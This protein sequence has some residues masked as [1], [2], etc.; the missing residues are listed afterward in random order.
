MTKTLPTTVHLIASASARKTT[1]TGV[2]SGLM[3]L[4]GLATAPSPAVA[5]HHEESSAAVFKNLDVFNLEIAADPQISPDGKTVIY[6]RRS[7][8]IMTDTAR[9]N[10]WMVDIDGKNHR[11]LL[12]G[13]ASYASPRWSPTGDRIAYVSS[14]EG[15][16]PQLFVRWMDT[17]Q[18]ALITN[19][20]EAPGA[21][22]WSPDGAQIAFTMFVEKKA[23]PLATP[24]AQPKGATWAKPVTVIDQV[25][26]RSDGAGYARTG[27]THVFTAPADGG[28]PV[29][30]TE[31]DFNHGGGVSWAPD[32]K[33]ILL[34]ANRNEGWALEPSESE[35][36]EL[37]LA[38]RSLQKL[39]T[40]KGP[41]SQPRYSP[42]GKRIAYL[43]F[44]DELLGYHNTRLYVMNRD[45]SGGKALTANLDR[46]I[47]TFQWADNN[48]LVAQFDDSGRTFLARVPI[49]GEMTRLVRDVSGV[50]I[51][52]PYT[53]GGFSVNT[54]GDIAYSSGRADR[55]A[56]VAALPANG[57]ATRL[58]R[59]NDDLLPHRT[60]G[61]VERLTWKSSA[62]GRDVE[63]WLVKPPGFE[64]GKKYPLILEIHGGPFAAYGP[65]FSAEVQLYAAAGYAVLYTNPRGSTSYGKEFANLIHHAYPGN[66]YDDLVSGVD[67]AIAK[68]FV[69]ENQ[70]FVTGGSGGGVLTAWIVGKTDRFKAAAVQ[71]PVINWTSFAL[72]ADG[73]PFF[74][75]YWFGKLPWED[76]A[77]YWKRSPLSLVG[78]VTTP[79]MLI[80]GEADYRTPISETE[81]YYQALQL[82]EVDTV[83]VRI[84][85]ASHSIARRPSNLIAK[86]DNILAWFAR[87]RDDG[88]TASTGNASE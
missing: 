57:T 38:D 49:D 13:K 34:S 59:L 40:R 69:D 2:L 4:A 61:E 48:A 29:Q 53:S 58:T 24:P 50:S 27:F 31:G 72:T 73:Y 56:D 75:K 51:G 45:G 20:Q 8:D 47:S 60:L 43:G 54:K 25:G 44:D 26:Y 74:Y 36:W 3:L 70:L 18:T 17:G 9:S 12:S 21:I 87:Y 32:G 84:P 33:S 37:T 55:P 85:D 16:K 83:M 1:L 67:A 86:V 30:W 65:H 19:L 62:D 11:P 5:G 66:D 14:I 23:K 88:P 63:G 22:A 35:V 39:T 81:Q 52:R 80:T 79:T 6:A 77:A 68:G 42:D 10:L 64:E 7:M 28:T 78:N 82:R 41:D 71:K 46:S 76:Q 15:G